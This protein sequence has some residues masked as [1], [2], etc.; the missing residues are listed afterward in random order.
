MSALGIRHVVMPAQ[1]PELEHGSEP[2]AEHARRSGHAKALELSLAH[3]GRIVLGADTVVATGPSAHDVLGK[4]RDPAEAAAMLRLLS[5][6]THD[7]LT[8]VA[9]LFHDPSATNPVRAVVRSVRSLVCFR[10]LSEDF[11]ARYVA[12]GEPLDKAGAYGVQGRLASH[13]AR[14]E[15][16]WSNVVGLPQEIL[17]ELFEGLGFTMELWQDW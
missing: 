4:P 16:S 1:A 10:E 9:L 7:V 13:V 5:G 12:T 17:P 15:G 14:I 6:R 8:G 3:P 2:A 11:I